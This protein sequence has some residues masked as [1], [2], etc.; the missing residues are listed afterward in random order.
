MKTS[1]SKFNILNIHKPVKIPSN[2]FRLPLILVF[3][4]LMFTAGSKA[5]TYYVSNGGNDLN[6]GLSETESWQTI[7]KINAVFYQPG[8]SILFKSGETFEGSIYLVDKGQGLPGQPII[9]TNYGAG[10]A[11]ISSG[12]KE[13]IFIQNAGNIEIKNLIFQGAGYTTQVMWGA[14]IDFWMTADCNASADNIIVDNVEVF[15][16]GGF[17]ILFH[18][19]SANYGFNHIRVV[20]SSFHDNGM[21]GVELSAE[22]DSVNSRTRILHSDAYFGNSRAFYNRG[23]LDYKDNWS[24]CGFLMSSV[25][26]G[27]IENCEA[28]ENGIENGSAYAGPVGIFIGD[29]RNVMVQHCKSHNNHGG[30]GQR[31]GGGFD[32]DGGASYSVIQYCESYEN[33]GAGYGIYQWQ[34]KN[35]WTNDTIRYNTSVNDGRNYKIYGGI[36]SWTFNS[37]F[38]LINGMVYENKITVNQEGSGLKFLTNDF[39]NFIFKDNEF[40]ITA[41]GV[42]ST[43]IV[44]NPIIINS[45]FPCSVLPLINRQF[46][47][48]RINQ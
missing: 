10:V 2:G 43:K 28:Y 6:S 13:G 7:Q 22:W 39:Q 30:P 45:T 38:K 17:G 25:E 44:T 11:T 15:G 16:Y 41:P 37:T 8:D 18:S 19:V 48:R 36:T 29:C 35:P 42:Y 20:N 5:N 34:T 31:D 26:G 47:V 33:E 40:C 4:L 27:V 3:L 9:F 1:I 32:L 12:M 24:G 23:R 14:G 21:G 46:N